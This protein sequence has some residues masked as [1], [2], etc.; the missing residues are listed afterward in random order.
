MFGPR[1]VL[2]YRVVEG[3]M[4][5]DYYVGKTYLSCTAR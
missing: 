1:N 2:H 3:S 4:V 5:I